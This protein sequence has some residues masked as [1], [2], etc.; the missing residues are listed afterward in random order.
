MKYY[1]RLTLPFLVLV[2]A[3]GIFL[4]V[5][6]HFQSQRLARSRFI[7]EEHFMQI[8]E[9]MRQG[10]VEAILGGSPGDFTTTK[11]EYMGKVPIPPFDIDS[12]S[13]WEWWTGDE[14]QIVIVFNKQGKV[15]TRSCV[16][17]D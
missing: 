3:T 13:R 6:Q 12:D 15:K 8:K 16:R 17:P 14:G 1:V 9:G 10:E 2:V 11:V 5:Q 4:G 7:N